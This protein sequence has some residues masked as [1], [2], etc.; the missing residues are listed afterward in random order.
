MNILP[1]I[2]H[3]VYAMGV[4]AAPSGAHDILMLPQREN[5]MANVEVKFCRSQD[6]QFR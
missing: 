1:S 6:C 3:A 5:G 4:L 2:R